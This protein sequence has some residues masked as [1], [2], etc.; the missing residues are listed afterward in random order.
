MERRASQKAGG[1]YLDMS[2]LL[3]KVVDDCR[4]LSV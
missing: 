3:V 1:R 4:K 2:D